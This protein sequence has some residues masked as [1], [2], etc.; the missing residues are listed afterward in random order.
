MFREVWEAFV[1]HFSEMLPCSSL[2]LRF[3]KH[4]GC[5]PPSPYALFAS[6]L[7]PFRLLRLKSSQL[8]HLQFTGSL[9][10]LFKPAV[11][12]LQLIFH[13]SHSSLQLQSFCLVLPPYFCV[14]M[15]SVGF[16]C[17]LTHLVD[18]SFSSNFNAWISPGTVSIH[19]L[20][21]LHAWALH[22]YFFLGFVSSCC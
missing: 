6:L 17:V 14:F 8:T 15:V 12:T 4:I 7:S 21:F 5:G 18:L 20:S 16:N 1:H 9:F 3:W 19:S 13:V 22:F 10:C 11:E 2:H